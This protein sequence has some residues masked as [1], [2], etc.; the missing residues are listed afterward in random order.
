MSE[1]TLRALIRYLPP[2]MTLRGDMEQSSQLEAYAGMGDA[3]V[4]V[5]TGLHA[6]IARFVDDP[7]LDA[8]QLEIAVDAG[9]KEKVRLV[10]LAAGL[11]AR[12]RHR[13]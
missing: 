8:L 1:E 11:L 10:A 9:D 2:I 12:V 3:A 5:Y 7:Y 6:S 4:K 13:A